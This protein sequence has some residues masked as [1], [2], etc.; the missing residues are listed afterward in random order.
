PAVNMPV[1]DVHIS[2]ICIRAGFRQRPTTAGASTGVISGFG[3]FGYHMGLVALLHL[4]NELTASAPASNAQIQAQ[5]ED[6][7]YFYESN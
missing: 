1:G 3:A 5:T 7:K 4:I 6:H 2:H